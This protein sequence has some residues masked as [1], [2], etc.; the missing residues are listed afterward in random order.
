MQL[1]KVS[2]IGYR[3]IKAQMVLPIEPS[4]T[5]ILGAND[6]GKSNFLSAL[7][8]LN[9]DNHFEDD[10]LNWDLVEERDEY[11]KISYSF[12]LNEEEKKMILESHNEICKK[13]LSITV[14]NIANNDYSE[15]EDSLD[16]RDNNNED[17]SQSEDALQSLR[18][19]NLNLKDIPNEFEVFR[20]GVDSE[21]NYQGFELI[22][23]QAIKQLIEEYL[24]RVENIN[25]WDKVPDSITAQQ[26][27]ED[28]NEFMKGIFY[29]A[30]I[31]PKSAKDLFVQNDST[32]M[33][34][35]KASKTLNFTLKESWSQG[36]EL[37]FHLSHDSAKKSIELK[38][39]DPSVTSRFV[40]PSRRSSGFTHYFAMKTILHSREQENPARSYIWLFDEPGIYLHPA[41][42][43]D[44]LQVIEKLGAANQVL[45]STHSLFMINKSFPSRHR[46]LLKKEEGTLLDKKPYTG[47]WARTL[48][49]LGLSLS[50]TILFANYI[51]NCST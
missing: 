3:S 16:E 11:P 2:I 24:P 20:K 41:G 45:Y 12:Q 17:E 37:E 4:V 31:D 19:E 48:N 23:P 36:K 6:H 32:Q 28:T 44:M 7:N 47:Q 29:Y 40:R 10:D 18:L 25:S 9:I 34:L 14:V 42:Q 50:G 1:T 5:V 49:A 26:L 46:L 38:I 51:R 39:K 15:D 35:D 43:H 30:G 22:Y 33:R 8:H 13:I 27:H 21:L